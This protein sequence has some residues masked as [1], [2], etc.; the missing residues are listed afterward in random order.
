[1]TDL[2]ISDTI[3]DLGKDPQ[4]VS[5]WL[6]ILRNPGI[7]AKELKSEIKMEGTAI[8]YHLKKLE[9]TGLIETKT[10]QVE[11]TNLVQ[12]RFYVSSHFFD[13]K[14]KGILAKKARENPQKA[15]LLELYLMVSL[16]NRRIQKIT[17]MTTE[18]YKE[19]RAR[20]TDSFGE[21]FFINKKIAKKATT[22]YYEV[23]E[24]IKDLSSE[25]TIQESTKK[26]THWAVMACYPFI[27]D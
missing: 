19:Q 4:K 11:G 10:E 8:Y 22:K 13:E 6:E 2:Q 25:E 12:K 9:E 7:T 15:E 20:E 18:E 14:K 27:S 26:A 3:L 23:R 24:I 5:L 1:M 21:G 16:L 17:Q